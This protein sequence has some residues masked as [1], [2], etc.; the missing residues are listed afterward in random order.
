MCG[1]LRICALG[2]RL[3]DPNVAARMNAASTHCGPDNDGVFVEGNRVAL[4]M[5]RLSII[6]RADGDQ[7]VS[8][9]GDTVQVVYNGEIINDA[10]LREESKSK[11][12]R[13]RTHSDTEVLVHATSIYGPEPLTMFEGID[14][15]EVG[16]MLIAE[17]GSVQK[18]RY[19]RLDYAVDSSIIFDHCVEGLR[20][21]LDWAV[22]TG[23]ISDVPPAAFISGIVDSVSIA[24]LVARHRTIQSVPFR[25]ATRRLERHS[26][27]RPCRGACSTT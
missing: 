14:E 19:W 11:V 17:N 16:S 9:E 1:I 2:K 22:N 24:A 3:I 15:L 23:M 20:H 27:A 25:S 21:Q 4:A 26:T 6:D 7:R 10:S 5:R 12:H 18:C 13:F 8:N